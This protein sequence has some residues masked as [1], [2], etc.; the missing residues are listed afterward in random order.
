[1]SELALAAFAAERG[2]HAA[3]RGTLS[4]VRRIS[5][6]LRCR[7]YLDVLEQR[8]FRWLARSDRAFPS[9]PS[10]DPRRTERAVSAGRRST[11]APRPARGRDRRCACLLSGYGAQVARSLGRELVGGRS[12]SSS[13]GSRAAS[14]ARPIVA[15]STPA[16]PR[17]RCW[18]AASIATTPQPMPSSR[19]GS[20]NAGLSSR[21][22]HRASSPLRGGFPRATASSPGSRRPRSSSR[23]ASGA[24]R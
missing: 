5:R 8:G 7:E 4:A 14:T 24:A 9:A 19:S 2:V 23:R 21:S 16:G 1:M 18:A 10:R 13:A 17:S 6:G 15:R 12:S 22:T 20:P 11:G 3:A